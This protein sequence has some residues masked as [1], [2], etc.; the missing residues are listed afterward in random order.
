[1]WLREE[2]PELFHKASRFVSAKEYIF[3]RMTGEYL[4]DYGLAAG[5]GLLDIHSLRWNPAALDL[6]G[7][8]EDRLSALC[9][10]LTIHR[11]L[12]PQIAHAMGLPAGI[13]VVVGSSDAANS[14]LGAGAVLPGQAACMLG[15]SGAFRVISKR[16]VL[17]DKARTWCY[18]VD[19][20]HWLVGGAINNGGAALSWFRDLLGR[21]FDRLPAGERLSSEDV[22]DLAKEA[23][24]GAGGVICLPFFAGERSPNWNANARAAF[25]GMTLDH[26]AAHLSRSLLEAIAYRLRNIGEVLDEIGCDTHRIVASGGFTKSEFWLQVVSDVLD[27]ELTVP[28]WGESS[29]LGA[30][31]WAIL[32]MNPGMTLESLGALVE[33]ERRHGP[34]AAN[35]AIYHRLYPLY[36]KLYQNAAD[37]FDEVAEMQVRLS[38]KEDI[39][40]EAPPR[41][42]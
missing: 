4:V 12:G 17:D 14:S 35:A 36:L 21:Q 20:T 42:G 26:T 24:A 16:P 6:A 29:S 41:S 18:A 38:R 37:S 23:D 10:P 19:E 28:K 32:A 15:T 8:T 11:G 22:L 25:F 9:S 33:M 5:S 3:Q 1:M 39:P 13:P 27:R 31:F 2:R 34:D 7:I 30:A 40:G